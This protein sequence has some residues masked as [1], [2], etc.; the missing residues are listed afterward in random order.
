MVRN[1]I[2]RYITKLQYAL[3]YYIIGNDLFKE[4]PRLTLFNVVN[5]FSCQFV[6]FCLGYKEMA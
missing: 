5:V 6:Y 4:S 1:K 3:S 2:T